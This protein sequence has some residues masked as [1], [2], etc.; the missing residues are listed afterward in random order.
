[1][2]FKGVLALI[3]AADIDR[4]PAELILAIL[5]LPPGR[6]SR[7]DRVNIYNVDR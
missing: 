3:G 6:V 7:V 1:M 5:L 2:V 4:L